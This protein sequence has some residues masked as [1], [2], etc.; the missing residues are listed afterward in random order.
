M[1]FTASIHPLFQ[2]LQLLEVHKFMPSEFPLQ[3]SALFGA[4]RV[5]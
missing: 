3:G 5:L 2:V 4:E 1:L